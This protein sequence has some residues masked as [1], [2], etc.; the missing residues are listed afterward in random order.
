M[1]LVVSGVWLHVLT[2]IET[3]TLIVG[4]A[5][6]V[7]RY[8]IWKVRHALAWRKFA[9]FIVGGAFGVPVG[10]IALTQIN[11]AYLRAVAGVLLVLYSLFGL[12]RPA[13]TVKG[14]LTA[15]FG[16]EFLNGLLGALTGLAGVIMTVWC[17]LRGWPKDVQR[18][19]F[20][21]TILAAMI[22]TAISLTLAGA[23]TAQVA[24]LYHLKC[25]TNSSRWLMVPRLS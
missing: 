2:P 8:G 25:P 11:L 23:V 21:P 19:I 15:D 18:A 9:P 20:Q 13:V 24:K 14:S 10:A 7:Q 22:M 12:A 1:G 4:Y 5:L 16:I 3:A 6:L 17:Q